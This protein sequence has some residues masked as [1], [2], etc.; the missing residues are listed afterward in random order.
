MMRVIADH[1]MDENNKAELL[2]L[3]FQ[4]VPT[5]TVGAV[6][7]EI[8]GHADI[9]L[10]P[11]N[12]K[13]ICA[14]EVYGY[15][16]KMLPE[17]DVIPGSVAIGAKYP[18]DIA[19]NVC[20]MGD[21]AVCNKKHTAPEILREYKTVLD[22]R[23]GYAKCSVCVVSERAAITADDGIYRRL[24]ENG[25][26]SLK[27][28]AGYVRLGRMGGFIGGASGLLKSGL[29]VFNGDIKKHPDHENIKSFCKN[30][31]VDIISL[32]KGELYDIGTIF[33]I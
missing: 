33:F 17:L 4:V 19:Y 12:N 13:V 3:G 31:G 32:G 5:V 9:Q 21:T 30:S 29:L 10:H 22:T 14:P 18:S 24:S 27:I 15:Y 16:K 20:G 8:K 6:Y 28:R 26:D 11:V 25:F 2:K 1:R 7:D 23:Q